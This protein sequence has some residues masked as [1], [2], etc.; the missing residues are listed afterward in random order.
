MVYETNKMILYVRMR[1]ALYRMLVALIL[2][3]KKFCKDIRGIGFHVNPYDPCVA[4]WQ[5][6]RKQ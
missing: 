5:V 3:Y 6:K 4:N 1:R 2:Y